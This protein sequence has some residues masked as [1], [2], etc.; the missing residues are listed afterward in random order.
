MVVRV[1]GLVRDGYALAVP[2]LTL[3]G[4]YTP[5]DIPTRC[6]ISSHTDVVAAS[7]QRAARSTAGGYYA[8]GSCRSS[9]LFVRVRYLP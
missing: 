4:C 3:P 2:D 9:L 8:V 7:V 5:P 1:P 6:W